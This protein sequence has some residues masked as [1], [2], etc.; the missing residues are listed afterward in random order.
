[1]QIDELLWL[2]EVV[3][4]LAR[5]HDISPDEVRQVFETGP[6][7]R[8]ISKGRRSKDENVYAAYGQTEEGRYLSVFFIR[9]IGGA[10]LIISAR[11]MD[12]K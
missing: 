9:K 3:D 12:D 7:F 11:D 10:A 2:D 4:K 6:Y 8:Y 1:M 5:K